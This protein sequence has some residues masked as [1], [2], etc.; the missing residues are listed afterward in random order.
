M[1]KCRMSE[2]L[3]DRE[4]WESK[5]NPKIVASNCNFTD[6]LLVEFTYLYGTMQGTHS[7]SHVC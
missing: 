6:T 3:S 2:S 5:V 7:F 1:A 4:I